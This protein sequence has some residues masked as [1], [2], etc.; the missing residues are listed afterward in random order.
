VPAIRA[1]TEALVERKQE[2]M[3]EIPAAMT[4]VRLL[5][6]QVRRPEPQAGLGPA[7]HPGALSFYDKDKPSF[8]LAHA[9]YVGL[10][11]TVGLMAG[12]WIWELKRWMQRKQKN[13]AD[14]Y[15]NRVVELISSVQ[16]VTSLPPLEEIWQELVKILTEA[17]HDLDADQLSEESFNSFRAILQIGMEVTRERRTILTSANPAA[18]LQGNGA[19]IQAQSLHGLDQE[20]LKF[21]S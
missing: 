14:H 11:L 2:I 18:A 4:E 6:V 21:G 15:S 19:S 20:W 7:L 1:L 10:F 8:L 5:L 17:V 9:D 3:E 13:T 16:E 12:S